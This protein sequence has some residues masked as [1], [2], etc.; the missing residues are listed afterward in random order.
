MNLEYGGYLKVT[1]EFEV[2][3]EHLSTQPHPSIR[4]WAPVAEHGREKDEKGATAIIIFPGGGYRGLAEHEGA[5]YAE[6]FSKLGYAC[7]VVRYRVNPDGAQHPAML[8]DALTAVSMIRAQA[9]HYGVN[10]SRIGV[11]GSSAGG[12]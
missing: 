9:E 3:C 11:M 12:H 8:E 7:F 1:D 2:R 10:P 4:Y 6:H 5:G